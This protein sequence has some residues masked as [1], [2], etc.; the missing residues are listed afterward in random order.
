MKQRRVHMKSVLDH[1]LKR[2]YRVHP[3]DEFISE[4]D[5]R[6]HRALEQLNQIQTGI[7]ELHSTDLSVL[8]PPP[9]FSVPFQED[10]VDMDIDMDVDIDMD[11]LLPVPHAP[12]GSDTESDSGSGSGSGSGSDSDEQPVPVLVQV[13]VPPPRAKPTIPKKE[14]KVKPRKP[15]KKNEVHASCDAQMCCVTATKNVKAVTDK[16]LRSVTLVGDTPRGQ[17]IKALFV[18]GDFAAV[19]PYEYCENGKEDSCRVLYSRLHTHGLCFKWYMNGT[20]YVSLVPAIRQRIR[21]LRHSSNKGH[22]A[23]LDE[24]PDMDMVRHIPG[25]PDTHVGI[26]KCLDLRSNK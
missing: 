1:P 3:K 21:D 8:P 10:V 2:L 5:S 6:L 20:Y 25:W 11:N 4:W 12:L 18:G 15:R 19:N 24:H 7:R 26:H 22:L 23:K 9:V 16:L 13:Y 17:I 14:V